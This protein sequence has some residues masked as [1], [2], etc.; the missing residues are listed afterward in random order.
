MKKEFGGNL[1]KFL[2]FLACSY[3][4]VR[5]SIWSYV[6]TQMFFVPFDVESG[7][8][9]IS[10]GLALISQYGQNVALFL[11]TIEAG[12]R[13]A[14]KNKISTI[15]GNKPHIAI[16]E[17]EIY[18]SQTTSNL[19][20][21]LFG[22]FALIDSGTNLGQFESTTLEVAKATLTGFPLLMFMWVGRAISLVVVFV[23]ELFMDTANAL[24]H[25]LNDLLESMGIRRLP[26]LDLFVDPDKI[27][28]TRLDERNGKQGRFDTVSNTN[29]TQP[30]KSQS[31]NQ[32]FNQKPKPSFNPDFRPDMTY[33]KLPKGNK[34]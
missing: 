14:Y 3:G 30:Y 6:Q 1:L 11:C 17:E 20:Y 12:R 34:K 31:L 28:A 26:S 15:Q 24:L 16:L 9:V 22:V 7:N 13:L 25:A 27:L 10:N 23:E 21:V 29:T 19:Y 18:K 2:F 33:H 32:A 4:I 8:S 5:I